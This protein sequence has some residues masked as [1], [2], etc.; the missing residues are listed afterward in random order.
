MSILQNAE[1]PLS[2]ERLWELASSELPGV[3]LSTV[4]RILKN[5]TLEGHLRRLE[6]PE[7]GAV[8][9]PISQEH[10][11][12]FVCEQCRNVL[13]LPG[14]VDGISQ[15]VPTG[16][17]MH[18]H[19]FIIFGACPD[20]TQQSQAFAPYQTGSTSQNSQPDRLA[21]PA[22]RSVVSNFLTET[23][24]SQSASSG[25]PAPLPLTAA[26]SPPIKTGSR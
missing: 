16:S 17:Q 2:V 5:Q 23:P 13:Y 7:A 6:L 20:C 9:E 12:Y 21:R 26:T 11:H 10:H 8:Y 4:Y 15:L 24:S 25:D 14:C 18:R 22:K 3:G 19:E 1:G